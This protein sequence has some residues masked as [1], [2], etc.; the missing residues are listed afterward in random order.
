MIPV[1]EGSFPPQETRDQYGNSEVVSFNGAK[2][3]KRGN[4]YFLAQSYVNFSARCLNI[5]S[6]DISH[7]EILQIYNVNLLYY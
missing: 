2:K 4:F 6:R 3:K 5:V 1:K 7:P